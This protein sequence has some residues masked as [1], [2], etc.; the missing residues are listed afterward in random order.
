MSQDSG[1]EYSS[2][3]QKRGK[4]SSNKKTATYL[5]LVISNPA[6]I[7]ETHTL[8]KRSASNTGFTAE[9]LKRGDQLYE[10]KIQ[11]CFR[12]LECDLILEIEKRMGKTIAICDFSPTLNES[13]KYLDEDET[14]YGII[15]V[16]FQMKVLKELFL[17]C[18]KHEASEL[19]IYMDD[20]QAEGFEIYQDFLIYCDEALTEKGEKTKMVISTSREI[21]DKWCSFMTEINLKLEQDLWRE[22]RFNPV[23]R[24]YLKSCSRILSL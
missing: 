21:F 9:I 6:P 10:M 1:F 5:K 14:L 15:A 16:Q 23:I 22:Q 12:D 11:D 7:Q 8:P 4:P 17:F 19:T 2:T 18:A 24:G 20:D 13:N 3:Q